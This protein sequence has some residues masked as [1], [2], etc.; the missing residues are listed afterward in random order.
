ME[1]DVAIIGGG[2]GGLTAGIY[3]SRS[4]LK[5]VLIEKLSPGGQ[6]ALTHCIENYPGVESMSGYDLSSVMEKQARHFGTEIR[7]D[8]V[9]NIEKKDDNFFH[10]TS[11]KETIKAKAVIAATGAKPRKLDIP[12]ELAFLSRGVS[13]C[14]VCDG[15]FFRNKTVAV[16]GGGNTAV[17]EAMY[18]TKFV[19]K[20]YV[21]H[22]RDE[23]R[24]VKI[25][26]ER[27]FANEKIEFIW[28]T[29]VTEIRGEKTVNNLSLKNKK[30]GDEKLL[31]LDGVFVYVGM[32][33]ASGIFKDLV[34][35]SKSGFIVTDMN[36]HTKTPGLFAVGDLRDKNIWQV[37]V[38]VGD[39]SIAAINAEKYITE[40]F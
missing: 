17:E 18:L 25:I 35:L 32:E 13:Y 21:I 30:T 16:I 39:G 12:G 11:S 5:T 33:P 2:P 38:A 27:A 3:T 34:D 1:Y 22:R 37:S 31:P 10:I 20:V 8:E 19:S 24:S 6:I 26:Q 9:L 40:N 36:M 15:A 14:A 23:L 29:I 28:D 7:I 4:R